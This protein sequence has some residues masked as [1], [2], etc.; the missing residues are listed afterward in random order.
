MKTR[1]KRIIAFIIDW[2]ITLFPVVLV[3]S[4][5]AIFL[6]RQSEI[7]PFVMIPLF[8]LVPAAFGAFVLR[9]VLF[10]GRSL[11]KRIF[12]LFVYDE[13][14]LE[15]ASAERRL[16][17]NIFLFL[18][19]IDGI[20]LLATGKTIG[21][22]AAGTLVATKEELELHA[23]ETQEKLPVSKQKTV[24]QVVTVVAIVIGCLILFVGFVQV[25]LNAQKD[26]QQYQ[27]A[28]EYFVNS[29]S[30]RELNVEES[31]I[32]MNEYSLHTETSREDNSTTQTVTIGF[33]VKF[34]SFEVV[35]HKENDGWQVC[36]ECTHFE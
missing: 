36:Q 27:V 33:F 18:Y 23:E 9:D 25:G 1:L 22:R 32:R 16:L 35:C 8:L 2:N 20:V 11:G 5:S 29:Q 3:F 34:K 28:Y 15:P 12:G 10:K 17:R 6:M 13:K 19:L 7:N 26:T 21:D 4:C 24:K 30:F 31:K 14:T